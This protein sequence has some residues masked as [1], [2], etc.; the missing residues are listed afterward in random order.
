MKTQLNPISLPLA[1]NNVIEASAGTGKT[2]TMVTLYLRL[3]LQAGKHNFPQ[4]LD[5]EQILVVTFTKDAT[6]EL[7]QRINQRIQSWLNLLQ[8]YQQQQ[9]KTLIT[10]QELLNLLPFI[11]HNLPLAIQRLTFA[12]QYIDRAA[13]FTIHSFC[14]RILRQYAFDSGLS[15]AFSVGEENQARLRQI[16]YQLWREQFYALDHEQAAIITQIFSSPDQLFE[17]FKKLLSGDM[18][19]I[20]QT[21]LFN[22]LTSGIAYYQQ[23]LATFSAIERTHLTAFVDWFTQN[24]AAIQK[25]SEKKIQTYLASEKETELQLKTAKALTE[26]KF[27]KGKAVPLPPFILE[28]EKFF[29][30]FAQEAYVASMNYLYIQLLRERIFNYQDKHNEKSFDDLLRLLRDALYKPQAE[31]LIRLIRQQYPFAMI[32]EFQD[33]DPIQLAIFEKIY[34]MTKPDYPLANLTVIGD[35]K[36]AIYRFRGADIFTY[37]SIMDNQR[38]YH[39]PNI[40]TL[41]HN[42]RSATGLIDSLNQL[43]TQ[44]E[45]PF[46][47][48]NIVFPPIQAHNQ[49]YLVINEKKQPAWQMLQLTEEYKKK[50]LYQRAIAEMYASYLQQLLKLA[51]QQQAYFVEDPT[52]MTQRAV[53]AKDIAVLVRNENESQLIRTALAKKG[54]AS[55]YLSERSNVFDSVIAQDLYLV[56]RACFTPFNERAVLSAIGSTL[57]AFAADQIHQLK[58][59]EDQWAAL[60]ERFL[61]YRQIWQT[62]GVL[63]MLY[64]LY[65]TENI[66]QRLQQ[67]ALGERYLV[68]LLHLSELLQQAM[69]QQQN[70]EALLNWYQQQLSDIASNEENRLRLEREQDVIKIITIHKSKG[71]EFPLVCL[72]FIMTR[73]SR[74]KAEE[75]SFYHNT[76]NQLIWDIA[77]EEK[78]QVGLENRAENMRLL[79]VALTR[80]K[81]QLI[82]GVPSL[83]VAEDKT[84]TETLTPL[85]YLLVQGEMLATESS[86]QALFDRALSPENWQVVQENAI[87]YQDSW[88]PNLTVEKPIE[89][90]YVKQPVEKNWRVTSF[91]AIQSKLQTIY[92]EH[93]VDLAQDYFDQ[94]M[95]VAELSTQLDPLNTTY[96]PAD[97]SPFDFPKGATVG[98]HLHRYLEKLDFTKPINIESFKPLCQILN[99]TDDWLAP[100]Q[101]WF[102]Q[103]V[104][105]PLPELG[106]LQHISRKDKLTEL[107]FYLKL[108]KLFN[109]QQFNQ[110]LQQYHPLYDQQYPIQVDEIQGFIRGFIDVV[111]RRDNRY[112]LI[113]YK[114]N[115]LGKESSCYQSDNLQKV[116]S[117]QRYDLQYLIYT[118]ALHRYLKLHDPDY[119]Y[120]THFGGVF[121]LFVRGMAVADDAQTGIF[122][123]KPATELIEKLDQL[124]E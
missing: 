44:A 14:Q 79:Y 91:T 118:L 39:I 50:E 32:D 8:Q 103:V 61:E 21:L 96:Y 54:L 31:K 59:N 72:P 124:W 80:A 119:Q 6:K 101:T 73:S 19:Q 97:F 110:I 67:F 87:C 1:Q 23:Q 37:L 104:S 85:D 9:D 112:Y 114:S 74:G 57:W 15:F 71:L 93:F 40:Y 111:V 65:Q 34:L 18:P 62:Q 49:G 11:E 90:Q 95:Q 99:L 28:L 33:T 22:D 43:Y 66:P 29:A 105:K 117:A 3:L 94:E 88:R 60:I 116:I 76:E 4:P 56:L 98:A 84:T 100:L 38:Q 48:T 51:E 25:T 35:P 55:V 27:Y 20:T 13:I 120:A 78:S 69:S 2:Y 10:D 92:D 81:Y 63:P 7:R 17:K 121:Y 106:A 45:N 52:Q 41:Q 102:T 83:P 46:Y 58:E 113:D 86:Y 75:V 68:D 26:I 82:V 77:Q 123:T 64:R 12:T 115:F 122:F 42:Y 36:Q 107:Q 47:L 16:N 108:G 70:E 30:N 109:N 89:V 24:K 53:V 5:I